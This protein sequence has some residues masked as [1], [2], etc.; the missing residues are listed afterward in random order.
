M[1]ERCPRTDFSPGKITGSSPAEHRYY[2]IVLYDISDQKKYRMLI[3]I[4]K[5]YSAPIQ[6][7]VFEA[8]LTS[9]QIQ[10]LVDSIARL[11]RMEKFQNE[12][13]SVRIYRISG[14]CKATVFGEYKSSFVEDNLFI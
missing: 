6:K 9:M 5:K 13:D 10:E 11:M 2:V 14:N 8:Y 12:D 1:S 4:L 7:S 3:K